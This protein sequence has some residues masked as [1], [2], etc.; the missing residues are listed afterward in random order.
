MP[1][2]AALTA[3]DLGLGGTDDEPLHVL[4]LPQ[5]YSKPSASV[6]LSI[7][8]DLRSEPPS[9]QATPKSGT[10]RSTSGASTPARPRRKI[11]NEGVPAYLTKIISSPLVWIES[12]DDRERIWDLAAKRLS[13]RSGRT[14]M[15]DITRSF[16]IPLSAKALQNDPEEAA[17]SDNWIEI[18]LHE[19]ALAADS[20][21]L[22]TWA[23]SYLLAKRLCLLRDEVL[24]PLRPHDFVLELGAGTGLVGL[25]AAVVFQRPVILTDLPAIVPNLQRNIEQNEDLLAARQGYASAAVLDWAS[26][27]S[28]ACLT[29]AGVPH[30]FPLILAA[31]PVYDAHQPGLLVNAIGCHVELSAD[32]SIVIELPLREDFAAERQ[33]LRDRMEGLGLEIREQGE[34]VGYDDWTDHEG[35]MVEVRCWWAIWGWKAS[36]LP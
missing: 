28:F 16:Q 21:G 26:P 20:L 19:P 17:H 35:E 14:A 8:T 23:S 10:P 25:A 6:L 2:P 11:T 36:S 15:G 7:L 1:P 32:A 31:D 24:P 12:E 22:K 3:S 34:E 4:D 29:H 5:L 33:D 9:W 27:E 18:T 13:E 30:A